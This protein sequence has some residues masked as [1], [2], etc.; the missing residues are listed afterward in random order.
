[1]PLAL[2]NL[3]SLLLRESSK[4]H[5]SEVVTRHVFLTKLVVL[6]HLGH[7]AFLMEIVSTF[8]HN[9]GLEKTI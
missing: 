9:E 6:L 7:Y 5:S 2:F 3:R 1:M 8:E 4:L